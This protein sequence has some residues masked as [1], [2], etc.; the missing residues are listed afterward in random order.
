[1]TRLD[2]A[3]AA[4]LLFQ[5][6]RESRVYAKLDPATQWGWQELL[7]NKAAN[8]LEFLAWTKTKDATKKAPQ[9]RPKPF[10]PDFIPQ[11]KDVAEG[12]ESHTVDDIREILAKA[13][14]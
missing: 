12:L 11:P 2:P 6:P 1:M 14:V 8:A 10:M 4:R 7:L 9:D 13:R 5:L 3:K